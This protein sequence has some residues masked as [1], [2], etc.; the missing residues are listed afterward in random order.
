M[1]L[2][3][4]PSA[5]ARYLHILLS[6]LPVLRLLLLLPI[7]IVT[8]CQATQPNAVSAEP[9]QQAPR[10]YTL[11]PGDKIRVTVYEHENLSGNFTVDDT[12]RLS[13]PLIGGIDVKGISLPE[14]EKTIGQRLL[15]NDILNPKVSAGLLELR[16]FCVLGEVRN[17]GCFSYIHG[18]TASRAVAL[19]GGYTYR[20]VKHKFAITRE[21]GR[22]I[23]GDNDTS[24]YSGDLVEVAERFF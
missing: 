24:V 10:L 9:D 21:D 13:L 15:A 20:A 6:K 3:K 23:K 18:L 12:G 16:P 14:L 2:Q 1:A 4:L 11:G 7:A 19:A 22:K 8:G 17:P 5:I